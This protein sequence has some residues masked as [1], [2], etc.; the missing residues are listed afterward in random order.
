MQ[1]E[2]QS[3][4]TSLRC[5]FAG[6]RRRLTVLWAPLLLPAI[7]VCLAS[8]PRKNASTISG[9]APRN[10]AIPASVASVSRKSGGIASNAV[11]AI[12]RASSSRAC[13]HSGDSRRA[14]RAVR[15]SGLMRNSAIVGPPARRPGCRCRR[16]LILPDPGLRKG[17]R[18]PR[19]A[20]PPRSPQ[21]RR[22]VPRWRDPTAAR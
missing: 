14:F 3:H 16:R 7:A 22:P 10:A 11:S 13:F 21:L 1:H 8:P 5:Y 12:R 18:P 4:N 19:P 20:A 15:N 2:P 17:E 9:Q 6:F